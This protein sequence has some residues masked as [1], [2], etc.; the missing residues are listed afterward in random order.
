MKRRLSAPALLLLAFVLV[1]PAAGQERPGDRPAFY[2]GLNMVIGGASAVAHSLLAANDVDPLKAFA[3]GVLGGAVTFGGQELASTGT[4]ALRLPGIQLAA[5]GSNL[6]RNA[7]RGVGPLSDLVFPLHPFYVRIRPGTADPV[8]VRLSLLSAVSL[9]E[10]AAAA[11]RFD[12][13]MD[14]K[15]TLLTGAP[16]FRSSSSYIYPFAGDTH[17]ACAHG[18]PCTGWASGFHRN[19]VSWYTTGGRSPENSANVLTHEAL[20]LTQVNRDVI[21]HAIP[22]SDAALGALGGPLAWLTRYLVVD[23]YQPLTGL[24]E[25][26][27]AGAGSSDGPALRP[28]E[29]E[30][31]ALTGG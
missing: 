4:P 11:D 18:E 14:V 20:H 16:V 5:V 29:R 3:G 23:V 9:L 24:N 28:Y 30:V 19:G 27:S 13:R 25:L 10:A 15:Q 7:G 17:A 26:L 8:S 2:L 12:A 31:R 21:L 1:R 6:A 22:A